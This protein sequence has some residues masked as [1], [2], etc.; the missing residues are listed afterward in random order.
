MDAEAEKAVEEETMHLFNMMKEFDPYPPVNDKDSAEEE[1]RISKL[2]E[3][4]GE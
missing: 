3:T 1:D 2:Q 4:L